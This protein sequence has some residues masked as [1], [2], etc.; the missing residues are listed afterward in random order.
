MTTR[1][2]RPRKGVNYRELAGMETDDPFEVEPLVETN[3]V[4]DED[5]QDNEGETLI[6][7][8][9]SLVKD[10][11]E[12]LKQEQL[13]N[14]KL[15]EDQRVEILREKLKEIKQENAVLKSN[16]RGADGVQLESKLK[17]KQRGKKADKFPNLTD[18]RKSLPLAKQ[19]EEYCLGFDPSDSEDEHFDRRSGRAGRDQRRRITDSSSSSDDSNEYDTRRRP[20]SNDKRGKKS[21]RSAAPGSSVERPQ[22]WPQSVL[23]TSFVSKTAYED[24]TVAEFVA[25]Y[26]TI[27]QTVRKSSVEYKA[28][29]EHLISL[30][31]F[32]S[33]FEWDAILNYHAAVLLDIESGRSYWGDSFTHLEARTLYGFLKNSGKRV[34]SGNS[35]SKPVLFCRDFQKGTCKKSKDHFGLVRGESKFVKHICAPCWLNGRVQRSHPET[36]RDCPFFSVNKRSEFVTTS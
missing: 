8:V 2:L 19:V 28:R 26:V 30:M 15:K 23:N 18:L 33:T 24:L 9:E 5:L 27:L 29:L 4:E 10:L 21:G 11:D 3:D 7:D 14:L 25:G 35:P 16:L 22:L 36:S 20:K 6:L 31:Y 1:E 17:G 13:L 12:Q 32:A 34:N